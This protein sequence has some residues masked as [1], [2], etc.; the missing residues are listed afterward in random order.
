MRAL[1][2]T[3]LGA[4]LIVSLLAFADIRRVGS[5]IAAFQ[6]RDLLI[7]AALMLVYEAVRCM[8]WHLLLAALAI[9]APL[10]SQIFAFAMGEV[11]KSLPI[12]NYFQNYVLLQ[13][14][15][16]A[17]GRSSAATTLIVLT[18]VA[19]SV[20]LVAVL[21]LG[22]WTGWLRPLILVGLSVFALV[23]WVVAALG[24]PRAVLARLRRSPAL[25]RPL[26]EWD[27]FRG[28]V[29]ALLRPP[30]LAYAGALGA[31]YIL[32]GALGL[33]VLGH[34]LN[35][36]PITLPQ[37]VSAYCF[38]LACGL[39]LP[40]PLDLGLIEVSGAG[41]LMAV[42]VGR[43]AAVGMVIIN[44]AL[45]LAVALLVALVAMVVLRAE[46]RMALLILRGHH[47]SS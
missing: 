17:F 4:A 28:G 37:A 8:Q 39:I 34:G 3:I 21:G 19:V 31:A 32:T 44:R 1:I 2:P 15:G 13:A 29:V 18:E 36:H 14:E 47:A 22:A 42:G 35:P 26:A 5:Q 40:L 9:R 12:G 7:F 30:A 20:T 38:S 25:R 41:A 33:F 27:A 24:V 6:A 23:I 10:R 11:T 46:R 45:S 16:T 43:D